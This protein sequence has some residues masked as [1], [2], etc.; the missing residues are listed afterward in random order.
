MKPSRRGGA[1]SLTLRA[2]LA[3]IAAFL[4]SCPT[5]VATPF[6]PDVELQKMVLELNSGA[7]IVA[8][9]NTL[10]R[11]APDLSVERTEELCCSSSASAADCPSITCSGGGSGQPCRNPVIMLTLLPGAAEQLVVCGNATCG[12]LEAGACEVR[13]SANL[14]RAPQSDAKYCTYRYT[15]VA[16]EQSAAVAVAAPGGAGNVLY[17]GLGHANSFRGH[18]LSMQ[19]LKGNVLCRMDHASMA[20]CNPYGLYEHLFVAALATESHA[21]FVFRRRNGTSKAVA[22]AS[23]P[24][25]TYVGRLC[26]DDV[27]YYS[28]V[29]VPLRKR[30]ALCAFPLS[31]LDAKI[32]ETRQAC[33]TKQ[34]PR[35]N[36]V[37]LP[38]RENDGEDCTAN[39]PAHN[40]AQWPC[41]SD[42]LTKILASR[43]GVSRRPLLELNVTLLSSVAVTTENGHTVA[44]LGDH[45]GFLHKA[46]LGQG[47]TSRVYGKVKVGSG[48]RD[49][50]NKDSVL[51]PEGQYLYVLNTREVHRVPVQRCGANRSCPDCL[52]L[53]DPYCG[54]C[55]L[56]GRC[57]RKTECERGTE[58]GCWVQTYE[59]TSCP[60]IASA[61]PHSLSVKLP[62]TS[63]TLHVPALPALHEGELL[64][65]HFDA[66]ESPA[67]VTGADVTCA[68]SLPLDAIPAIPPN[69]DHVDVR[70][71]VRYGEV[72]VAHTLLPFYD[73]ERVVQDDETSPCAHCVTRHW[74]CSW[75]PLEFKCT[76]EP[77]CSSAHTVSSSD[78]CPAIDKVLHSLV[79]TGVPRHV[80]MTARNLHLLDHVKEV[81]CT[82]LVEGRTVASLGSV[83]DTGA[84]TCDAQIVSGAVTAAHARAAR[85]WCRESALRFAL[86]HYEY[87][88]QS[89][90]YQAEV[91]LELSK[92]H[93]LDNQQRHNVTLYDCSKVQTDCSECAVSDTRYGCVW[94]AHSCRYNESCAAVSPECPGP[95]VKSIEP[96]TGVLEGGTIL[97]VHGSDLGRSFEESPFITKLKPSEG[98]VEGGTRITI[99]GKHLLTGNRELIAAFIG[100]SQCSDLRMVGVEEE[101]TLECSTPK[102]QEKVSVAVSLRYGGTSVSNA[103]AEV[104]EYKENPIISDFNPK[105]SFYGGGRVITVSGSKLNTA[106]KMSMEV[107]VQLPR[108]RRSL[109]PSTISSPCEFRSADEALCPSP[110]V[111]DGSTVLRAWFQLDG[112]RSDVTSLLTYEENPLL[113]R[114]GTAPYVINGHNILTIKG[115]NLNKAMDKEE[116]EVT[117]G[118]EQCKVEM[119]DSSSLYCKPPLT[120]PS[121]RGGGD[122]AGYGQEEEVHM[123]ALRFPL[124]RVRYSTGDGLLS[125]GAIAGIAVGLVLLLLAIAALILLLRHN[126]N[127]EKEKILMEMT[128]MEGKVRDMVRREFAD[129][130]TD[131]SDLDVLVDETGI[132]FLEYHRYVERIFFPGQQQLLCEG[133]APPPASPSW[134]AALT[135][136]HN[137]LN[138]K[139]FLIKFI[140]T[141][142][143]QHGGVSQ[144]HCGRIASLVTVVLHDKLEYYTDILKTQ[145]VAIIDNDVETK[146]KL[147]FRRTTTVAEKMLTNWMSICLYTHLRETGGKPLYMLFKAIKYHVDKG[148]VDALMHKA[149]FTLDE[150]SLLKNNIEHKELTLKVNLEEMFAANGAVGEAPVVTEAEVRV[151]DCDTVTQ[152][153]EKILDHVYRSVGHSQRPKLCSQRGGGSGLTLSDEDNTSESEAGMWDGSTVMLVPRS[154]RH[155][156]PYNQNHDTRHLAGERTSMLRHNEEDGLASYH[157]IKAT[158]EDE[159][160]KKQRLVREHDHVMAIPEI[161]LTRL[162][163]TALQEMVERVFRG[164]LS[165]DCAVPHGVKYFLDFLD[166]QA[167]RYDVNSDVLRIWKS[168]CLLLRFWTLL[169]KDP[170]LVFDVEVSEV[171]RSSLDIISQTFMDACSPEVYKITKEAPTRR[172]LFAKEL[173]QFRKMVERYYDDVAQMVP[174]SDQDMNS[175]LNRQSCTYTSELD[176]RGALYE[177]YKY[178]DKYYEKIAEALKEDATGQLAD[179]FRT[180]MRDNP[181]TGH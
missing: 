35:S 39:T 73:C 8:G 34:S 95:M 92:G 101:A 1:A 74:T 77:Q 145:L 75:C 36:D 169:L 2:A 25:L 61:S 32:D 111:P 141:L 119:M 23:H 72:S 164:I 152:V 15:K 33:Y 10:F 3:I 46:Y 172:L 104:F 134:D 170:Q 178:A 99:F 87:H 171:V 53:D 59:N 12:P 108:R 42:H 160:D 176:M 82:V 154:Q 47:E 86:R 68:Q 6:S 94:C 128:R 124:G 110:T 109:H 50:I 140:Q 138:S 126:A 56:Q 139:L 125:K 49:P 84:V 131:M 121:A 166:T 148:P 133:A 27:N 69:S 100:D 81:T 118:E 162:L 175:W 89:M 79:P 7:L 54:W 66:F 9:D 96:H 158:D 113:C 161:Y 52:A 71:E 159:V 24:Y 180:A 29:E 146:P 150:N 62:P 122:E 4:P 168:N 43:S 156:R 107:E 30:S 28:Y 91:W 114:P 19:D 123:G 21:F 151:L 90:E 177:L 44:F 179:R 18:P 157:L 173:P 41:G 130:V 60:T 137:L 51:D 115:Q 13:S 112:F 31:A 153:K 5:A 167:E 143:M 26:L 22:G 132:P 20:L 155:V 165:T 181:P 55:V 37:Y 129:L 38:Y 116:V 106:L 78:D 11:L 117:I 102:V 70:V 163:T 103:S 65:C 45:D 67:T 88:T 64:T 76:H 174:V 63:V 58:P 120:Q 40:V 83:D 97:T 48:Q 85:R 147:L 144:A 80:R 142:E 57:S 149:K 135:G 93:R 14:S 127:R 17:L 136:F 105:S 16:G 98:P